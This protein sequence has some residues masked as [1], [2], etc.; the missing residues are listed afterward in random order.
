MLCGIPSA[1]RSKIGWQRVIP[2]TEVTRKLRSTAS[3][4]ISETLISGYQYRCG[5]EWTCVT[6]NS[7]MSPLPM[8]FRATPPSPP[9]QLSGI[10]TCFPRTGK[11]GL[12]KIALKQSRRY[13]DVTVWYIPERTSKLYPW[14]PGTGTK[15][16]VCFVLL[17]S[18]FILDICSA[19]FWWR[20]GTEL[21][22]SD[23]TELLAVRFWWI[24]AWSQWHL[25][26]AYQW[27]PRRWR[28]RSEGMDHRSYF[29]WK[30]GYSTW[31]Q[32]L[33]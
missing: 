31:A 21:C 4:A 9:S 33:P 32:S 30:N 18:F 10:L 26:L 28:K 6:C 2:S 14:T 17:H 13:R 16:F 1:N 27:T 19:A 24:P 23:D 15:R 7:V 11:D 8:L 20:W 29:S 5:T 12:V 25:R 3:L 22:W